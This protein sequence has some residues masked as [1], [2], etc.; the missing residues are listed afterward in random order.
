MYITKIEN[1][2]KSCIL[3]YSLTTQIKLASNLLACLSLPS[4]G[5]IGMPP[6]APYFKYPFNQ[7]VP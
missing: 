1:N 4:T 5:I 2:F 3:K 6:P 7:T